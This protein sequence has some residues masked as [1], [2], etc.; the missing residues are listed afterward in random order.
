MISLSDRYFAQR[1]YYMANLGIVL[2]TERQF[3]LWLLDEVI[4]KV[5]AQINKDFSFQAEKLLPFWIE[6]PPEQRG[7]KPKGESIPL[8]ELGEK[9]LVPH[10]LAA[11]GQFSDV[12]FPGLPTGGDVRFATESA[13][14]HLDI[15]LTGPNDNPDEIVVPPNQVSGD[16][17]A[18]NDGVLNSNWP[19]KY[20]S[21]S[22]LGQINYRFQP[23]LP[24]FYLLDNKP[25]LCITM[26]LKA[27][28]SVS[29]YGIQPLT[30]FELICVPN[31][32][33]M[34]DGPNLAQTDGLIISGKDDKSKAEHSRRIRIRLD[35]LSELDSW[36]AIK[37]NLDN[38]LW[39]SSSRSQQE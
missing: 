12:S 23:K 27:V 4:L 11:L 10:L 3:T 21:R 7:R 31:G 17:V 1:E 15:K 22:R 18:W 16:G 9:T 36:R 38:D 33:L 8:L 30:Y 24:P 25:L 2:E 5:A 19:V 26:F 34:F 32:L 39:L 29:E 14:V 13:F 6:Y 28:Y 35:P 37:I 20:V